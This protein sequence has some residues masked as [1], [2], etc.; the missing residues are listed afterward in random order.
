[1]NPTINRYYDCSWK[2]NLLLLTSKAFLFAR[3]KPWHAPNL[4]GYSAMIALAV[5][6]FTFANAGGATAAKRVAL[7]LAAEKYAHLKPSAISAEK[8]GQLGQ[9]L[10]AKGFDVSMLAN[11]NNAGARAA[12]R[13]FAGKAAAADFALIIAS[14]HLATYSRKSFYLPVNSRVRRA[15]DLF[16]RGLSVTSIADIARRAKVGALVMLVTT[17]DIP[18]TIAGVGTRPDVGDKSPPNLVTVFSTSSKVPVTSVDRVSKQ[19]AA[20]LIDAAKDSSLTLATLVDSASAGGAGQII[21]ATPELDLTK[22]KPEKKPAAKITEKDNKSS[23]TAAAAAAAAVASAKREAE[24]LAEARKEAQRKAQAKTESERRARELAERRLRLAEERARQAERR[25]RLAEEKAKQEQAARREKAAKLI[26]EKVKPTPQ[27][28]QPPANL[29]SLQV[30]EALLGRAQRR[31]IQR[32]LQALGF[33]SGK[34]DAIFGARTRD[35][36]K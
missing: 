26:E 34:L 4:I 2:A 22:D 19:A 31:N 7:L 23:E 35:A 32:R 6:C 3:G 18:S 9:S 15:T 8:I 16:S 14:G 30:V 28:A 29:Q 21:G 24:K 17:P 36:I 11:P 12:L 13:E 10:K 27:S 20:D 25:A 5:I 1:M 33:Y